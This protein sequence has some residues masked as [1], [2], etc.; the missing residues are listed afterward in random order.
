MGNNGD[1][2]ACGWEDSAAPVV[3]VPFVGGD[4]CVPDGDDDVAAPVAVGET[5]AIDKT[6]KA[7]HWFA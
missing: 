7:F 4:G 2:C 5:T 1:D 6:Q 3:A